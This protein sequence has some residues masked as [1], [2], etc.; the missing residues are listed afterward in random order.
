MTKSKVLKVIF[1]MPTIVYDTLKEF[2]PIIIFG[3][4]IMVSTVFNLVQVIFLTLAMI[5]V[6]FPY[7]K[8][9]ERKNK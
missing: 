9:F 7:R 8:E 3:I 4:F 2:Q 6:I 1:S 5:G